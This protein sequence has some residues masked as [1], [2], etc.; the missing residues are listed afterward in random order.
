MFISMEQLLI[1]FILF[2]GTV[3]GVWLVT[4]RFYLVPAWLEYKPFCC[5]ICLTF[6]SLVGEG[7]LAALGGWWISAVAFWVLAILN[8]VAMKVD[9][10]NK[11]ISLDDY[12][13][14]G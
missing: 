12:D 9:Q 1:S 3:W 10:K 13:K 6:W 11:T 8:A 7:V 4:E 2:I 5:R 14:L